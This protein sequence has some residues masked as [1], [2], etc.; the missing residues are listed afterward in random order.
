I[1][2]GWALRGLSYERV[3]CVMNTAYGKPSHDTL[4]FDLQ[5]VRWPLTYA[6][7]EGSP[8][9]VRAEQRKALTDKLTNAIRACLSSLA[10]PAPKRV[11]LAELRELA[12]A[13][14]WCS[15]IQSATVGDNDWWTFAIRLRQAAVDGAIKFWGRRYVVDFG[16]ALDTEALVE[17]PKE[18]FAS[19]EF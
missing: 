3:I 2:Y 8:Q 19:F 16:Q 11:P 17:I 9:E 12:A 1:E 7:P 6:L 5:H 15:D 14:G 18:H 10:P 13:A 4:P